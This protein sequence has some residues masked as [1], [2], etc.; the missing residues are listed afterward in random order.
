MTGVWN[1]GEIS[2][3]GREM[4]TSSGERE[5]RRPGLM[6]AATVDLELKTRLSDPA[7]SLDGDASCGLP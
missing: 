5:E 1:E 6:T 4:V 3:R 2:P 7:G